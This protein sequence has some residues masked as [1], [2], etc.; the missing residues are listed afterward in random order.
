MLSLISV[1]ISAGTEKFE[2]AMK[3]SADVAEASLS[4]AAA[5]ADQFQTAF[6]R[7]SVAAGQSSQKMA[8]DFEAAND[9]IM[10]AADQSSERSTASTRPRTRWTPSPGRKRSPAPSAPVLRPGSSWRRPGWRRSKSSS[11]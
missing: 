7:A 6:D 5:N 1:E 4:A 3:R 9:R 11:K 2:A 8:S 10:G